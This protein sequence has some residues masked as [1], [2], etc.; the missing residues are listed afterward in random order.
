MKTSL[1]KQA[2]CSQNIHGMCILPVVITMFFL[3]GTKML[4][5][6][7]CTFILKTP[8]KTVYMLLFHSKTSA[9]LMF[10]NSIKKVQPD[11]QWEV[12]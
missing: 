1:R 5:Y 3:K 6:T 2:S 10:M 9:G 7:K 4:F 8:E 12:F 11:P